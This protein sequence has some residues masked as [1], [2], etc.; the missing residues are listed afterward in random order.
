MDQTQLD[1]DQVAVAAAGA[2]VQHDQDQLIADQQAAAAAQAQ[3][4]ADQAAMETAPA[5]AAAAEPVLESV[6]VDASATAME[7]APT[8]EA[9]ASAD[10]PAADTG[11]GPADVA[12]TE[13]TPATILQELE[14][15]VIFWGGEVLAKARALI[16]ELRSKL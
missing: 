11:T 4:E 3:L 6:P 15:H 7:T 9:V 10:Q 12:V 5:V 8:A 2:Q 14:E 13:R 16:G 1:S